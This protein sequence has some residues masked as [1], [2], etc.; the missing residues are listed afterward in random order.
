M[1][2]RT[3]LDKIEAHYEK[4]SQAKQSIEV[5]EWDTTI[6]WTPLTARENENIRSLAIGTARRNPGEIGLPAHRIGHLYCEAIIR[7]AT[8]ADGDRIFSSPTAARHVLLN[9]THLS[10]IERIGLAILD[11]PDETESASEVEDLKN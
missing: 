3:I 10:I 8:D 4:L 11:I 7:K 6:Y 2:N 5:P 1:D 9:K